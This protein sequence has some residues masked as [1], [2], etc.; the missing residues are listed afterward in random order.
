MLIIF[1]CDG[2]L[3]DSEPLAAKAFSS[4]LH[5]E[6]VTMSPQECMDE[7]RGHTLEYCFSWLANSFELQL[8]E[9]FANTLDAATTSLF[10]DELQATQGVVNLLEK[11]EQKNI[12]FC[13]ASNGGHKKIEH[14]LEITGLLPW[15]GDRR[16]SKEDVAQ[17]KPSP[18]LF[19]HAAEAMGVPAKFATVVEDSAAGI[20]AAKAA[21]MSVIHF[22]A[23]PF[24]Q[25]IPEGVVEVSSMLELQKILPG[26]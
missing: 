21:G 22:N 1:D 10:E 17:G 26:F 13:V 19:L 25:A 16:F 18:D 7:F 5:D 6:G 24:A 14:S 23:L 12:S 4:C 8:P 2:V 15:F 20:Q 9:S 11:V 3:V